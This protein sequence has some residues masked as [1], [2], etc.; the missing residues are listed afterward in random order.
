MIKITLPLPP[1]ANQNYS[2]GRNGVYL[3][4]QSRIYRQ[5]VALMLNQMDITP[6]VGDVSITVHVYRKR[7]DY[8]VSNASK[9]LEDVLQG[10]C[11]LDDVQIKE[12]HYYREYDPKNPR[13]EIEI[14]AVYPLVGKA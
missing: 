1:S 12:S 14:E 8:D 11:Y 13:V 2:H 3:S 10:Y 7:R 6:I 4:P 5:E 9:I